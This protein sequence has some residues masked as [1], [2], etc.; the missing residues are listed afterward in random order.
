MQ[1]PEQFIAQ[2]ERLFPGESD[3]MLRAISETNPSVSVRVNDARD[4]VVPTGVD[5]VPWCDRGFYLD[6]RPQFTFD[7]MWHAGMYYVQD[8]SSMFIHHVIKSLVDEPAV[9]LDLCAAPGGKTTAALQALPEGSL[10]VANEIVVSRA[11]VLADNVSRWGN[12][13]SA[14]T[15]CAPR[16]LGKLR[17]AFDV[18]AADVPCSGEGM[19]RKDDE[20]VSQWSPALVEQCADRQRGII[21]DIWPA[22][23]PG[24]LFIYST[25]TYN[26]EENEQMLAHIVEEYGAEVLEVP[27]S[28]EWPIHAGVN[29]ELPCYRFL[30]H[31]T[32]GEGL[33]MA[34][35]R[36]PADEPVRPAKPGKKQR[37]PARTDAPRTLKQWLLQE[38]DYKVTVTGDTVAAVPKQYAAIIDLLAECNLM[39][40]GVTLG[41]VKGKNCVPAQSLALSSALNRE[42]FPECKLDYPTAIAYLRGEAITVDAPRGYALVTYNG[43]PLGWINNLGNRAN[44][45]Y[46]KPLRILSTHAPETAPQVI[47]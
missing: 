1:L 17:H 39:Q 19:M 41:T 33:F 21:A 5:T 35:L 2:I 44:N 36:K 18:I 7:P 38:K 37:T 34:V 8:A 22:L 45:M 11:R 46:P 13:N 31:L 3:A 32:R 29:T 26:T 47:K 40:A 14:V 24:G 20:A 43:A 12:P 4:A 9:F 30:P 23:K 15:C 28:P 10:V 27:V 16:G 6:E 25:C 42:E